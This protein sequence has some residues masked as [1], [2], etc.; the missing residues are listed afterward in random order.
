M[1]SVGVPHL[2]DIRANLHD[3]RKDAT[4]NDRKDAALSQRR[5]SSR[6]AV[7]AVGGTR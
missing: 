2:G 5:D 4:L 6:V 7:A 1:I 3:D